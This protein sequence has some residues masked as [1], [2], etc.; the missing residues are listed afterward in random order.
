[1]EIRKNCQKYQFWYLEKGD[2][3]L[4]RA[5]TTKP[6]LI[7]HSIFFYWTTTDKL[8]FTDWSWVKRIFRCGE[9][10]ILR[11]RRMIAPPLAAIRVNET[12]IS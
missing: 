2:L 12:N 3:E 5:T 6:R 1:M 10:A 4:R 11:W 8:E 9:N 7:E